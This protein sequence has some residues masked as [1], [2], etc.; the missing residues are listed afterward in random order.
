MYTENNP[1]R[2]QID[3]IKGVNNLIKNHPA[4]LKMKL[5]IATDELIIGENEVLV[6]FFNKEDNCIE[7]K[8]IEISELSINHVLYD[9]QIIDLEND[10]IEENLLSDLLLPLSAIPQC[11]K[12]NDLMG[13][14]VHIYD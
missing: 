3:L 13:N 7:L 10:K 1:L 4:G 14:K 6:Q 9:S 5:M 11:L 12:R 8:P 2:D